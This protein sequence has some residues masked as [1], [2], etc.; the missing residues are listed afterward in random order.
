MGAPSGPGAPCL[1]NR[2]W[3]GATPRRQGR[4]CLAPGWA[5]F[6]LGNTLRTTRFWDPRG[7]VGA[8]VGPN[9]WR[10][11]LAVG[12]GGGFPSG[13]LG[14]PGCPA[15]SAVGAG[16]P[17]PGDGNQTWGSVAPPGGPD[18]R[19]RAVAVSAALDDDEMSCAPSSSGDAS[20]GGPPGD[21]GDSGCVGS[22]GLPG[23]DR[24]GSRTDPPGGPVPGAGRRRGPPSRRSPASGGAGAGL[25]GRAGGGAGP[26]QG[27]HLGPVTGVQSGGSL[28]SQTELAGDPDPSGVPGLIARFDDGGHDGS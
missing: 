14:P 23:G 4:A 18:A 9:S 16:D 3:G 26:C 10:R 5:L 15:G 25:A 6:P 27:P 11:L 21:D 8:A 22:P 28:P 13:D 19:A 20:S 7:W 24:Q 12:R 17:P 2:L 1:V